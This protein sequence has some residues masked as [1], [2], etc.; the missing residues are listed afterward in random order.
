MGWLD[1]HLS[2][3]IQRI[4]MRHKVE[5][6]GWGRRRHI[7]KL[8]MMRRRR[9]RVRIWSSPREEQVPVQGGGEKGNSPVNGSTGKRWTKNWC[10]LRNLHPHYQFPWPLCDN[11]ENGCNIVLQNLSCNPKPPRIWEGSGQQWNEQDLAYFKRRT[12]EI[13][14]FVIKVDERE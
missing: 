2:V 12:C 13:A 6:R 1:W 7:M 14:E 10:S 4:F 5:G 11:I 9:R 3:V 8:M